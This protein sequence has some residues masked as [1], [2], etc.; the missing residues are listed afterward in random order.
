MIKLGINAW[1]YPRSI[2]P[3]S[4]MEHAKRI[5][6]NGY[7]AVIGEEDLALLGQPQ[8]RG[9]W[10]KISEAS[11]ALGIEVPSIA[12]GLLWS[13]N[14]ISDAH[15]ERALAVVEA[16]CR[17]AE[18]VGARVILVIP[19]VGIPGLRYS[20]HFKRAV[21]FLKRA[22]RIA[23]NYGVVVGVENVW[24]RIFSSPQ[25]FL[26]LL[27]EAGEDRLGV[28][29]DVANTL[30]HSLAEHWIEVLGKRVVQIHVKDLSLEGMRFG[31]PSYGDVSWATIRSSLEEI[32]YS[33][34]LVAEVPPY[35]G[36]PYKASEDTFSYLWKVFGGL[37]AKA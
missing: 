25:E 29:L 13:Y 14:P 10:G 2:D 7:E 4:A 22:A 33:G 18:I 15:R 28:Y 21:D 34:Y 12:T 30:P 35:R 17:A 36:D 27:E 24:G 8:F 5:G 16:S 3:L 23:S 20:D 6:Y 32:G 26:R 37:V 31:I 9:K 19:G 11:S 1:S